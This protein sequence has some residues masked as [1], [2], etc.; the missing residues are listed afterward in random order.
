MSSRERASS[1]AWARR[2][3]TVLRG[4]ARSWKDVSIALEVVFADCTRLHC[5]AQPREKLINRSDVKMSHRARLES[6]SAASRSGTHCAES[7]CAEV[8]PPRKTLP[9]L[10]PSA[11]PVS[12]AGKLPLCTAS[13]SSASGA[14][15]RTGHSHRV[16]HGAVPSRDAEQERYEG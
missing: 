7:R 4:T 2:T 14:A 3:R 15:V 1:I 11:H 8:H 16:P 10:L 6:R 9:L 12:W 13:G 5:A